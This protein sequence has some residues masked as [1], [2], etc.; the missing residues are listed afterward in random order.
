MNLRF[1]SIPFCSLAYLGIC[2]GKASAQGPNLLTNGDFSAN[3]AAFTS[4]PAYAGGANP[5]TVPGW[6]IP[7]GG[8]GVNGNL[9]ATNVFGPANVGTIGA[10]AFRQNPGTIEQ[11]FAS[12]AGHIYAPQHFLIW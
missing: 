12:L 5:A 10:F 1:P 4:W 8:W 6:N 7:G 9:T 3:A 11:N 2:L